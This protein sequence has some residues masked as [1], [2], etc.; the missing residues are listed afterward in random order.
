MTYTI[1][2]ATGHIGQGIARILLG[3][4]MSVRAIGRSHDRLQPLI[5]AGA[6]AL[7]GTL[8]DSAF[9]CRAFDGADAVFAMIPPNPRA[10]DFRAFQDHVGASIAAAV[11]KT[12]VPRVVNLSSQGAHL[13]GGTGPIA[14]LH[15]RNSGSTASRTCMSST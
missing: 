11:Q 10:Q 5:A 7:V 2:G 1:T 3:R 6:E 4:K 8:E 15:A 9:L 14:G 12:G 13:S